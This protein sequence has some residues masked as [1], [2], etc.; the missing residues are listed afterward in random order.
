[1]GEERCLGGKRETMRRKR[2]RTVGGLL[3]CTMVNKQPK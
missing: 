2:E 1:L 3:K